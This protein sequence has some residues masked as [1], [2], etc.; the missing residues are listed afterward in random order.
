MFMRERKIESA[1]KRL[2]S[3]ISKEIKPIT[4]LTYAECGYKTKNV[5]DDN[6]AFCELTSETGLH[7]LD[8]H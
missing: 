2:E 1:I 3:L 4:N 7:A 5:P 8:K 6:L